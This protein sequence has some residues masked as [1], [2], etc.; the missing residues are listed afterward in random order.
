MIRIGT[1]M[2]ETVLC[3]ASAYE[4]KYYFNPEFSKLPKDIQDELQIMCVK[5]TEECGGVISVVF[6]EDGDIEL[7]TEVNE[8][9]ILHDGISAGIMIRQLEKEKEELFEQLVYFYR[10]FISASDNGI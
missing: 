4:R 6:N 9:D 10:I 2:S 8:D 1:D 7:R 3:A 5:Y